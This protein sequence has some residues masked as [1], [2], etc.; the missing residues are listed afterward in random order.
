MTRTS[1]IVTAKLAD[2]ETDAKGV[3]S[4]IAYARWLLLCASCSCLP[5][6][7]KLR[8]SGNR[9]SNEDQR[10]TK[11]PNDTEQAIPI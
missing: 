8:R 7:D 1:Q 9:A 10:G 3:V 4:Q 2:L 6:S 11:K 5:G